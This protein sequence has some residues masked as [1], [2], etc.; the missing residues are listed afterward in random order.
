MTSGICGR[1]VVGLAVV[2]AAAAGMTGEG[3]EGE[4]GIEKGRE[5]GR[6]VEEEVLDKRDQEMRVGVEE[7]E[8]DE[9]NLCIGCTVVLPGSLFLLAL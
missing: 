8:G 6:G 4:A 5:R 7:G 9:Y 2:V 3:G 1:V